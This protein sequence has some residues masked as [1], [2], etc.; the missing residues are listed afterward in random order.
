M[1]VVM[2]GNI[3]FDFIWGGPDDGMIITTES[4][5]TF[6]KKPK[7]PKKDNFIKRIIKKLFNKNKDKDLGDKLKELEN[8]ESKV[9]Y[10]DVYTHAF[11]RPIKDKFVG[12]H[13]ESDIEYKKMKIKKEKS[14]KESDLTI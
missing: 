2:K 13:R 11:D 9:N 6:N 1:Q 10:E 5:G 3:L 12:T 8:E 7:K 14:D 4:G